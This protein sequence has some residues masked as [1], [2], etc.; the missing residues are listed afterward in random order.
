MT[1]HVRPSS[2]AGKYVVP[3]YPPGGNTDFDPLKPQ[4]LNTMYNV[5]VLVFE[6]GLIMASIKQTFVLI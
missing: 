5:H 3:E 6:E 4:I 1:S 2:V